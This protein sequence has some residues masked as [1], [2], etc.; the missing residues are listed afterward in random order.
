MQVKGPIDW[1]EVLETA[2]D[3]VRLRLKTF[4]GEE[5]ELELARGDSVRAVIPLDDMEEADS[6]FPVPSPAA[7]APPAPSPDGCALPEGSARAPQA[8]GDGVPAEGAAPA[9]PL[10]EELER[11][12]PE[13]RSATCPGCGGALRLAL[14]QEG[15]VALCRRCGASL[16]IDAGLL[17]RLADALG[18]RCSACGEG[19]LRSEATEYANILRCQDPACAKPGSWRGVSDRLR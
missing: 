4:E 14:T 10:F 11:L 7:T 16:R 5:Y 6:G 18:L 19:A 1:F 8:A 9:N 12:E 3:A 17:Q 13:L 15:I 2:A